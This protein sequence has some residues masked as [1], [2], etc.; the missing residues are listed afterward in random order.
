MRAPSANRV[1]SSGSAVERRRNHDALGL[2]VVRA[3]VLFLRGVDDEAEPVGRHAGVELGAH[4][5][6][7][8]LDVAGRN[9][10]FIALA[11][12]FRMVA[13][14][15]DLRL[16]FSVAL[17]EVGH[18]RG[19]GVDI[20]FQA[21]DL[22]ARKPCAFLIGPIAR[23]ADQA[24]RQHPFEKGPAHPPTAAPSVFPQAKGHAVFRFRRLRPA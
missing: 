2:G 19:Q 21:D 8:R 20:P 15:G 12:F 6:E 13:G 7:Q 3:L 22:G 16:L 9:V 17:A 10:P 5:I 23:Q 18:R 14:R 11:P 4:E 1:E 24:E